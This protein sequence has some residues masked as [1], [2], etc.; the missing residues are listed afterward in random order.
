MV[1]LM[2]IFGGMATIKGS[3]VGAIILVFFPELLRFVGLPNSIAAPARQMIYGLVLV[4]I[5]LKR[6]QGLLGKYEFQD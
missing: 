3:I 5:V 6:P 4:V 2:I 1:L